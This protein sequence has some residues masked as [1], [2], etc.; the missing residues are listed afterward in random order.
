[1][2]PECITDWL[3]KERRLS[4]LLDLGHLKISANAFG[5]DWIN[6]AKTILQNYPDRIREIHLSENGGVFDE[7]LPVFED[8][9]QISILRE[10]GLLSRILR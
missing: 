5:F 4:L 7:H 1:M 8:S 10:I 6:A 9:A 2:K 3:D